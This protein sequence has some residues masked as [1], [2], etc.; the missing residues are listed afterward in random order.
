MQVFHTGYPTKKA[1]S[2]WNIPSR[3]VCREKIVFSADGSVGTQPV[4]NT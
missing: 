1:R 4:D 2:I 3:G